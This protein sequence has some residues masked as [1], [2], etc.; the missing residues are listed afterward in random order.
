M[1]FP[2]QR[3][4]AACL[5]AYTTNRK[6]INKQADLILIAGQIE[7]LEMG[8][9]LFKT[10]SAEDVNRTRYEG[11]HHLRFAMKAACYDIKEAK[12]FIMS[13]LHPDHDGGL[14]H[15]WTT[16]MPIYIYEEEFKHAYGTFIWATDQFHVWEN[17]EL[18][19]AQGWLSGGHKAW[20]ESGKRIRQLQRLLS[21]KLIFGQ[22]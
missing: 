9:I 10:V 16:E 20:V 17:Y 5:P 11:Y 2:M 7:H 21:A 12:A 14:K 3:L 22:D 13:H 19:Q 6:H 18:N 1:V 15:F 4:A 8:L